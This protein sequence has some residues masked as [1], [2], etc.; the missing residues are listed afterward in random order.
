MITTNTIFD[1][2]IFPE[3]HTERLVLRRT[4]LTDAPAVFIF[5]SDPYV[6]RFNGPVFVDVAEAE[7]L[8]H[9]LNDEYF[10]KSG[11]CW[12]VTLKNENKVIGLFGIHHWN[13]YHRRAEVGYDLNQSYWGQGIASEA[14]RAILQFGFEQMNLNRIY[15]GT[16][17]ENHE[18]VQLLEAIGFERE[19]TRRGFSWEDDGTFHD[20]AMFGLLRDEFVMTPLPLGQCFAC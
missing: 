1:F 16:I 8:I 5:R 3:L 12:G 17:A 4:L 18:S 9:E 10:N 20:S 15:A 2:K 14:L 13:K 6:Q 11:I 19:G 7:A